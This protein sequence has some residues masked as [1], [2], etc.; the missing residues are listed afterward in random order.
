MTIEFESSRVALPAAGDE[1]AT[2]L[3][4]LD[5][6]RATFAWKC[7]GL[8]AEGM[9]R[10]LAPS[11][12]TLAGLAKHLALVE[13]VYFT[14][15]LHGRSMPPPWDT[16]DFDADPDWEWRTALEDSPTELKTLWESAVARS[17]AAV[18]EALAS[19][20]LGQLVQVSD[21]SEPPN[22]RRT[23]VD[24]IEEYAR[25]TGHADILRE[26]VDGRVGEE[27]PP[28]FVF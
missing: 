17:R 9:G 7:F 8:S 18:S 2:L 10:T 20:D 25:H 3:G 4:A 21:W 28:T 23:L 16:V 14:W 19:G 27:A 24:M 11:T 5:R 15:R 22:L 12:V 26:S 1:I 13:D 6:I